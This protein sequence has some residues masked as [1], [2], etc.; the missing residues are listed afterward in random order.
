MVA[1]IKKQQEFV[2]RKI[3]EAYSRLHELKNGDVGT[4]DELKELIA[5]RDRYTLLSDVN[6]RLE[7]LDKL[8][9]GD[10]FWGE[11]Y[12]KEQVAQQ[13]KRV[14]KLIAG[15]D[16]R[17][18][19]LQEEQTQH[20]EMIEGLEAQIN[21]LN[22]E[23]ME[24]QELEEEMAEEFVIEREMVALPYRPMQMPWN[25]EGKD[26]KKF[27]KILLIVL[28]I[29]MLLGV[30]IPLW[31]IPIPDRIEVVEVPERLAKLMVKKEPPPPP[32]PKQKP[33]EKK[34]EKEKVKQD[35]KPV[36][37]KAKKAR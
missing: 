18:E 34:P 1:D 17:M 32:Q 35:K 27:R 4:S 15:Y 5:L 9:A 22:D 14:S 8:G 7:K 21:M 11:N 26:Q 37:E 16:S 33:E 6:D 12:D 24:L 10:L 13:Q 23:S 25:K 36:P 19:E 31:H 28:F 20:D 3:D 2:N 29:S 30:L